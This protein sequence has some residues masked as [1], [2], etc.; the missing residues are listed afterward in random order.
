MKLLFALPGLHQVRRGAEVAFESIAQEIALGGGHEVLLAGSGQVLE[1]RHYSFQHVDAVPRSHFE[2]WPKMPFL[3]SEFMYEDLSFALRLMLKSGLNDADLTMTCS[4]PYT[5]WALRRLRNMSGRIP[6]VFVTQNGDWAATKGRGE[7]K[8]FSCDGLICTNPLYYERNRMRW[9][10]TLIPNGVDTG[11]FHPGLAERERFG[12]PTD[13]PVIL[14]V[15]A[16]EAGKRVL[17]AMHAVSEVPD[18]FLLIAGDGV[19]REEVDKLADEIL[20]GRFRRQTFSHVDM[21]SLYRSAD[22]FLHTKI[23]ESFG[24]VYVEA[25]SS[26]VQIIAHDDE[27]TRWILEDHAIRVDTAVRGALSHAI[28]DA[29]KSPPIDVSAAVNFA[30][31]RYRWDVIA[32]KYLEFFLEVRALHERRS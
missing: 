31:A 15:S 10:A 26:G 9:H 16:L 2:K 1:G 20:P 11:R 28:A 7:P 27:V 17:E 22:L 5:N 18:A 6:H 23:R 21:P 25:L 24:N 13:R 30:N 4:Y 29:L 12:L 8:F 14:M 19:L 3:R 32:R